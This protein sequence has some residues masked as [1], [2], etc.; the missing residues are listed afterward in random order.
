MGIFMADKTINNIK[1]VAK[2]IRELPRSNYILSNIVNEKYGTTFR[3]LFID[4]D[5]A[6]DRV[7]A[8]CNTRNQFK[9]ISSF[10]QR[11][12]IFKHLQSI[13]NIIKK[14]DDFLVGLDNLKLEI[15][16]FAYMK[17]VK[18]SATNIEKEVEK[19]R[20]EKNKLAREVKIVLKNVEKTKGAI[21]DSQDNLITLNALGK[22]LKKHNTQIKTQDDKYKQYDKG[23]KTY[24]EEKR[25]AL[26][27][28]ETIKQEAKDAMRLGAAAG[29]SAAF[30]TQYEEIKGMPKRISGNKGA[31]SKWFLN[32]FIGA[33][34]WIWGAFI[35]VVIA[36]GIGIWL[37]I[38]SEL[39]INTVLARLSL[40]FVSLTSAGFCAGQYIKISNV[41]TDYA[42][43][44]T[45]AK[46]IDAFSE[47]L[48]SNDT[49]DT[50]YKDYIKKMLNEIHKHPLRNYK[51][52]ESITPVKKIVEIALEKLSQ[53]K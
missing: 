20:G 46:S 36:I 21:N 52:Q 49:T 34:P 14:D 27:E 19:L 32:L 39:E 13:H 37:S 45:L 26:A 25:V 40:I 29:I 8:L 4:L 30:Q 48:K 3:E 1:L 15:Q 50:S 18:S 51:K 41:A 6:I 12:N 7:L 24:K 23:I 38:S 33:K 9:D 53:K 22:T 5:R 31:L 11:D 2:A 16:N 47:K 42:Y 43:K 35:F 28:V 10:T 17:Y 44:A